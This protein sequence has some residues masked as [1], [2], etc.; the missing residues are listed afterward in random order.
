[1][2]KE[3][4]DE[5]DDRMSLL[6]DYAYVLSGAKSRLSNIV[7]GKS[8]AERSRSLI[9]LVQFVCIDLLELTFEEAIA[10]REEIFFRYKL[11]TLV[12]AKHFSI[13]VEDEEQGAMWI[14]TCSKELIIEVA[15]KNLDV[16]TDVI[17]IWELFRRIATNPYHNGMCG[18]GHV[19]MQ[20][21]LEKYK[22]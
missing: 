11:N 10:Q 2:S 20:K 12:S 15:Y 13:L 6:N 22:K 5:Y 17:E 7:F 19:A 9:F 21:G 14:P 16:E 1:M 4:V 18:R 3:T 8:E